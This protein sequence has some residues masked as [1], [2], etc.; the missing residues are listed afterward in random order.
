MRHD[1]VWLFEHIS[2]AP[3]PMKKRSLENTWLWVASRWMTKTWSFHL[4]KNLWQ[5]VKNLIITSSTRRHQ[6][7][8]QRVLDEH[9]VWRVLRCDDCD[10]PWRDICAWW[11]CQTCPLLCTSSCADKCATC[12]LCSMTHR[13]G[14]HALREGFVGFLS[15]G[16][17]RG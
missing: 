4:I 15:A 1:V 16:I 9:L 8:R 3:S 6:Q 10:V 13:V 11:G 17:T 2:R 5:Y 14:R 7:W 12:T